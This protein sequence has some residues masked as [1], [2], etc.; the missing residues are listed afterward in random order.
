MADRSGTRLQSESGRFNSYSHLMKVENYLNQRI[1]SAS[2]CALMPADHEFIKTHG[3]SEFIVKGLLRKKFRRWAINADTR[4]RV[5]K[6]VAQKVAADE[7][8]ELVLPFGGY[9]LWRLPTTPEV[10]WA[11]FF[12]LNHYAHYAAPILAAYQP[13][14]N[15]TLSSDD[16]IVARMDNI[17]ESQTRAYFD[18][19]NKLLNFLAPHWPA[20]YKVSIVR[21]GDLYRGAETEFETDLAANLRTT[22]AELNK[23]P[24]KLEKK[25]TMSLLNINWQGKDDWANFSESERQ[26]KIRLGAIM[27]DAYCA[28]P[29]RREFVRGADKIVIFPSA[30][31]RNGIPIGSTRT[32]ITKFW[33]GVGV[34]EKNGDAYNERILSPKQFETANAL[35]YE[36][37]ESNLVPLKNFRTLRIYPQPFKFV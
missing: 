30:P 19:F 37:I 5:A 17:D 3:F 31:I 16:I 10:D 7:P 25:D 11:E 22:E 21:I 32:S 27:H 26:A 33:T 34:L 24:A 23:D 18:S 2:K 12:A 36:I 28:L 1:D 15:L 6:A 9:K 29:R 20:N 14:V 4:A 13:G 8:L 35:P